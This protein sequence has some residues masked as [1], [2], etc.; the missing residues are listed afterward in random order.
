MGKKILFVA[1][2]SDHLINFHIPYMEELKKDNEVFTMAKDCETSFADYNINFEKKILSCKNF[3]NIKKIKEILL[4]NEFDIVVCNTTLASFFV[5]LAIKKLKKKPY[6]INIVH[7]YLFGKNT[8]WFYKR[9]L[10]CAEKMVKKVTNKIVVM[11]NED[12]DI[13]VLNKF[14]NGDVVKIDGMGIDGS[15][16]DKTSQTTDNNSDEITFSFVG[17]LSTR[18]NQKFL[19]KFIKKLEKFDI[20]AKLNL[21][22]EGSLKN[23]LKKI[24]KKKKLEDKVFLLGYDKNIQYHFNKTNYYVCA[25]VIEG[26]PFNI[27]EAMFAG[28]VVF[29]SDAKGNVDL[30]DDLENGVLFEVNNM[31]DLISKFRLVK[32]NLT[33]QEKIRKNAQKTAEKYLISNVFEENMGIFKGIIKELDNGK[34]E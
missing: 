5:R 23:K 13:A 10:I 21:I 18:K 17:E 34:S 31:D 14:S 19:I 25:S 28:S 11:N 8:N 1:S 29:S 12:Y 32:N 26:L 2:T 20:D 6:V 3:R 33:L 4:K 16:F 7:G 24:I 15:R 30:V 27:L 9:A 22:G